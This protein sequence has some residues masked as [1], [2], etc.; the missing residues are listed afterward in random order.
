MRRAGARRPEMV[1]PALPI[2]DERA[3][4]IDR[5]VL[6][7]GATGF[8]GRRV[9]DALL[10][11][12]ARVR[13]LVR[14][15]TGS[16]GVSWRERIEVHSGDLLE[17]ASL[18]GALDDVDAVV[19]LAASLMG[20]VDATVEGTRNLLEVMDGAGVGRLVLASSFSVY[21]WDRVGDVLDEDSAILRDDGDLRKYGDYAAAK[22]LQERLVRDHCERRGGELTVL[23]LG[24]VWGK[25]SAYLPCLGQRIGPIH[26]IIGPGPNPRL[27]HL[28]NCA[29]AFAAVLASERSIG[30]TFNIVDGHRIRNR[31]YLGKYLDTRGEGGTRISLPYGLA[32]AGVR[33][34]HALASAAGVADRLPSILVPCRFR[35]RFRRV[36]CSATRISSTLGWAPPYDLVQCLDATFGRPVE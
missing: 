14:P 15:A 29:D 9:V 1:Y 23:R 2:P 12:G 3:G 8:V 10:G 5:R 24:W 18:E 28:F 27:T 21:D 20:P 31:V 19:H 32:L 4:R 26:L 22:A 7:T 35:S 25:D 13:A 34:V 30:Q 6:I 17:R 36:D 33:V 11:R 16:G